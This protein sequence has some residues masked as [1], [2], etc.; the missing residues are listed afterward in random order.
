MKRITSALAALIG[1]GAFSAFVSASDSSHPMA[2]AL[3]PFIDHHILAGAVVLVATRDQILDLE[4][5]GY[6]D[7]ATKTRMRPDNLFWIASMSKPVTTTALMMLVDEGKVNLDDPVEKYLPEFK[8]Q[9][10]LV[11]KDENHVLL[12]RPSHPILVREILS[13]TS[14]IPKRAPTYLPKDDE[15]PL[16]DVAQLGA[17]TPLET[18]PGTNY[19]YTNVGIDTVG[20]V[21]EVVSGMPYEKF[22]A[23][24]L[25]GPLGM[26]DTT[27]FPDRDQ[28]K[29]IATIYLVDQ[30]Q[31]GLTKVTLGNL[32]YPLD[33][34]HRYPC[35]AAGLFSTAGDMAKFC[36]MLLAG[37]TA[38]DRRYLHESAIAIMGSKQTPD[39][40]NVP[41][42]FGWSTGLG[43]DREAFGHGGALQTYM[44]IDRKVGMTAVFMVQ[45]RDTWR[46][47]E[48]KEVWPAFTRAAYGIFS[49]GLVVDGKHVP[50]EPPP[51]TTG[52]I[53]KR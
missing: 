22:L 42:G 37:G 48:E 3:Q 5:M 26:K 20:R 15:V 16:R 35:P 47:A 52:G 10:V 34:P 8:G 14:G 13:H 41:Y 38:G 29:R 23:T 50:G 18:E 2:D 32:S 39:T 21:I 11:E 7:L 19:D 53:Y 30:G 1:C 40:I 25:F 9:M 45:H 43:K 51:D 28:V 31:T 17:V 24:R 36:Q 6:A 49:P 4:A 27:F 33:D 46:T 44:F 12:K